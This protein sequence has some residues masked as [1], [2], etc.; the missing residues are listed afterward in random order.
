MCCLMLYISWSEDAEKAA[1]NAVPDPEA[2]AAPGVTPVPIETA[3][4]MAAV[5]ARPWGGGWKKEG[6][7]RGRGAE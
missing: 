6:V 4:I 7:V 3:A 1:S 5:E 2:P